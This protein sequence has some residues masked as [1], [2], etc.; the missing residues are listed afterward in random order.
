MDGGSIPPSSTPHI[1]EPYPDVTPV[2][3]I[4]IVTNSISIEAPEGLSKPSPVRPIVVR[5]DRSALRRIGQDEVVPSGPNGLQL[6]ELFDSEGLPNGHPFVVGT[7]ASMLGTEHLNRY[8]LAAHRESDYE[9]G[10]LS[11]FHAPKLT[12]FLRWL[13]NHHGEPV[14]LTV[15]T[16]EHLRIYKKEHTHKPPQTCGAS[17]RPSKVD[18]AQLNSSSQMCPSS[19]STNQLYC[20]DSVKLTISSI[21]FTCLTSLTFSRPSSPLD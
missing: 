10:S 7:D 20:D 12:G 13:W 9:Q 6:V 18:D 17:K 15:T 3:Y 5:V 21:A 4:P 16:T 8:L 2:F 19:R 1:L 14:E 11:T